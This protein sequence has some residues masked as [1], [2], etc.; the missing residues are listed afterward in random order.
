MNFCHITPTRYLDIFASGRKTHLI[1]AHLVEEDKSYREWYA[2]EKKNNNCQIIL[3]N[4]AF[5]MFSRGL[6]MYDSSKLV[7]LAKE[8]NADYIVMSDYP[9]EKSRH[10]INKAIETY[11]EIRANRV[12]TFF[13]PQSEP[14]NID[15]LTNAFLWASEAP[16][17]D[18]IGF[19]ILAIP[20]AYGI[21]DNNKYHTMLARWKFLQ[22][23]Q[24]TG[25]FYNIHKHSKKLHMLG[26]LDG[27]NELLIVKDYLK[28]FNSW[29]SSAAVWCGLN[30]IKFDE[31]PTGLKDG[32]FKEH[33]DFS[34]SSATIDQIAIVMKNIKY[35]DN[36]VEKN[37][38][39]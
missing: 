28:F 8:V 36:I 6:P 11:A 14:G 7:N 33:V 37:R 27:P 3:D 34:H 15:D 12:K 39:K 23:L 16:E 5:E 19:S 26:M 18:M 35:I 38:W 2:N 25:F 32:K 9:G 17:V 21:T 22:H 13:C 4:S 24:D 1:L 31:S 20:M 10:T 30:D 29:D